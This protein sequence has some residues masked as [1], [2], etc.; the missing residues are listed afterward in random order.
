[1]TSWLGWLGGLNTDL[2]V[3]GGLGGGGAARPVPVGFENASDR[4][5][6]VSILNSYTRDLPSPGETV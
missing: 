6:L 5:A 3:L 2:L 1:M 4:L